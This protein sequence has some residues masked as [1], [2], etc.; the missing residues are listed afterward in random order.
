MLNQNQLSLGI[1][2]DSLRSEN[3]LDA[4]ILDTIVDEYLGFAPE[5]QTEALFSQ[6]LLIGELQ[7]DAGTVAISLRN[8]LRLGLMKPGVIRSDSMRVGNESTTFYKDIDL[9]SPTELGV[10]FHRAVN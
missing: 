1:P 9:F 8:L 10:A 2:Y 4:R 7:V 3:A 5:K 6:S